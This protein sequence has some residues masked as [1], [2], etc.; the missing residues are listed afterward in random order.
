MNMSVYVSTCILFVFT[1]QETIAPGIH[2]CDYE[3]MK[4]NNRSL[5]D[6]LEER[7]EVSTRGFPLLLDF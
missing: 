5:D 7:N 1:V 6:K 2:F 3:Q 4:M